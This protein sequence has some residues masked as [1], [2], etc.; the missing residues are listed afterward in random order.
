VLTNLGTGTINWS[1][2]NTSSWLSVSTTNGSIAGSDFTNLT[3]GLSTLAN[4]LKAA[5]YNTSLIFTNPLGLVA[6]LPFTLSIGQPITQNGGFETGD[7][8]DWT[9]SGNTAFTTVESGSSYSAYI[10]SGSCAALLG[11]R[12]TMGYLAQNLS[13]SAGQN[14]ILSLWL[15]NPTGRTPT[16]F[17][18]QWNGATIFDQ[19]NITATGWTNLQFLVTA[20]G[21]ITPLQF[22]FRNDPDYFGLDDIAV[23]PLMP[24]AFKSTVRSASNF[25]LTWGANTGFVYQ[26]EYKTNILQPNWINL[27]GATLAKTNTLTVTD[28]NAFK[29]SPQRYYRL[30]VVP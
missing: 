14:Y 21:S 18:V 12:T 4:T 23:T 20:T 17:Q 13:T 6:A 7:F 30:Q 22:G 2:I 28:T 3:A 25:Q 9:L 24:V 27:G 1:L 10:H 26:V 5:V 11:P 15:R 29:L 16:E 19:L 8:S